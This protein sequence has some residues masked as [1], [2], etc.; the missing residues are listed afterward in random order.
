MNFFWEG[1]GHGLLFCFYAK[2]PIRGKKYLTK[3]TINY[4]KE[5]KN[6]IKGGFETILEI[7]YY[8][9]FGKDDI[10]I[11]DTGLTA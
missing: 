11:R 4:I 9:G 5:K 6:V 3:H 7:F 1:K 2:T 8:P 10:R